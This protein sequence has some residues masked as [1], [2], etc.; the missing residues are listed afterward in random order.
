M[1]VLVTTQHIHARSLYTTEN[2]PVDVIDLA[3]TIYNAKVPDCQAN[4]IDVEN[5][6]IP[7]YSPKHIH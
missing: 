1:V 2:H 3:D 6:E 7:C 4:I 5:V